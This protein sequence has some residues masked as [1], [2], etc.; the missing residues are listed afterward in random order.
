MIAV[1]VE[2]EYALVVEGHAGQAPKGQDIVCSAM[3]M[4][5]GS[6]AEFVLHNRARCIDA[7]VELT[8]GYARVRAIPQK[9]FEKELSGAFCMATL[10]MEML[11]SR[12]PEYVTEK[13]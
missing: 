9:D 4:L 3:S 7:D 8:N 5:I 2:G 11:K 1:T 12:Y 13:T 10:G 6:L